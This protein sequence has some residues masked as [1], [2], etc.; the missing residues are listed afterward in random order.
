MNRE[1]RT[2]DNGQPSTDKGRRTGG[3]AA[4][5]LAAGR[6]RRMGA[7]KPLLPFG[8]KTVVET[9]IDSLRAAGLS[10][11]VVVVG[12]RAAELRARLSHLPVRFAVND[13]AGSEMGASIARGVEQVSNDMTAALV[14]LADH[15]AVTPDAIR[16]L[17]E[18]RAETGAAFVVPAWRGRGGHPVLIDLAYREEL[19]RLD[20]GRG[21]RGLFEA[22][23]PEVLRVEVGCPYVARD[24]DTWEDYRALHAEVFGVPPPLENP[25]SGKGSD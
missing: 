21:L 2:K 13:E 24:M 18:R 17:I 5:L 11:I 10:E 23:A 25:D 8:A 22:H 14:A 6:S 19:S 3:V 4:I 15:P 7:F 16:F 9:C 20:E 1:Q 12:H